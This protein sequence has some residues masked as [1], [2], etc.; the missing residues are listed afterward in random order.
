MIVSCQPSSSPCLPTIILN[1]DRSA[2]RTSAIVA[3]YVVAVVGGLTWLASTSLGV[4][5]GLAPH[6]G[7]LKL[8]LF[9]WI[10]L[11]VFP[12][13]CGALVKLCCSPLFD[14]A[15]RISASPL[16]WFVSPGMLLFQGCMWLL[17][18]LAS[19]PFLRLGGC[20]LI[21]TACVLP[22]HLPPG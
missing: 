16:D 20:W 22:L 9:M 8:G 18:S 5:G 4:R 3:G 14:D 2:T 12:A 6:A 15:A 19:S 13:L 17:S 21:G 7:V 10:E 1:L 11:V